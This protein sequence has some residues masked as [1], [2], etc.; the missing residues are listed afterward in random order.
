MSNK[1]EDIINQQRD[2]WNNFSSGW[3]KWDS[4][5]M[6]FLKPV[7][8]EIIQ[9]LALKDNHL[10]LDVASGTG[11]PGL[12]IAEIVNKGKVI[13][14]DLSE[15]MLETAKEHA[16]SR[17]IT[18]YQT[19]AGDVSK[20]PFP[21]QTFN[22]ISCRMGFMFFPDILST[23]QE[24]RRVLKPKGRLAVSVWG[25]PQQNFWVTVTMGT[26]S[27]MLDLQP[28]PKEAPGMFRCALPGFMAEQFDKSG[29]S[30]IVESEINTALNMDA[31]IYWEMITEI[32]APIVAA[33]SDSDTQKRD[34]I[35]KEVLKKIH[36]K[37]PN[38]DIKMQ[39]LALLI[40]G[41]A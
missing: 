15:G 23:L 36:G 14:I 3:K 38:G 32:G 4:V 20:L 41:E 24:M 22:A 21:D 28:P 37:F 25:S 39:G 26:I 5:T 10:V 18:N 30:N 12:T 29:F 27:H 13:G 7:G 40:S 31:D 8:D 1:F 35:K 6:Q 17:G 9:Q 19:E 33:M 34:Q 2:S 11:E 16:A